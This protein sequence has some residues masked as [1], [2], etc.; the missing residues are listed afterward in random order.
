[1]NENIEIPAMQV[2]PLKKICMTIGEIPTSY[3]ETMSYYEMLVW[4]THYLRDNIIPA[5]NN[6]ASA[7]QEVQTI[8]MELQDYINNYFDNLDV[9]EE[10]DIKI[11]KLVANG[12]MTN[13]IKEY[14]DPIQEAYETSVNTRLD[15][16]DTALENSLV[17]QNTILTTQNQLID[18]MNRK[19]NNV[20][21]GTPQAVSSTSDMTDTTKIYVLTTDGQWYYYDGNDWTA[22]GDYTESAIGSGQVKFYNLYGDVIGNKYEF[23]ADSVANP[24]I[25]FELDNTYQGSNETPLVIDVFYKFKALARHSLTI[26]FNGYTLNKT[27]HTI[28]GNYLTGSGRNSAEAWFN[29]LQLHQT[30]SY[31]HS[32]LNGFGLGLNSSTA[33]D[34]HFTIEDI[35]VYIN[36]EKVDFTFNNLYSINSNVVPKGGNVKPLASKEYTDSK[37]AETIDT[38]KKFTNGILERKYVID[39]TYSYPTLYFTLPTQYRGGNHDYTVTFTPEVY[40]DLSGTLYSL[41]AV[42]YNPFSTNIDGE[43]WYATGKNIRENLNETITTTFTDNH[44]NTAIAIRLNQVNQTAYNLS[45]NDIS[46]SVDNHPVEIEF[47]E[48]KST[49]WEEVVSTISPLITNDEVKS[50]VASGKTIEKIDS[51][52]KSNAHKIACWG[53]SLTEGGTSTGQPYPTVLNELLG[54]KYT[55]YNLGKS[56]QRS[57]AIAFREGAI[58]WTLATGITIPASTSESVSFDINIS[59]GHPINIWNDVVFDVS[60]DGIEGKLTTSG[61]SN[62]TTNISGSFKRNTAGSAKSVNADTQIISLEATHQADLNIIWMGLN[63]VTFAYPYQVTGP[64]NNSLKMINSL[65]PDVKR[66]L[67]ISCTSTASMTPEGDLFTQVTNLNNNYKALYPDQYV[68]LEYYCVHQLIYDMGITPTESDLANM[69]DDIIPASVTADGIHF[70]GEARVFIAEFIY[71]ELCVRGWV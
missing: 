24:F 45:I 38:F 33:S 56:G 50:Y 68:D 31:T 29:P 71:N 47:L 55:V 26:C 30:I 63:D 61:I 2:T 13:I 4:F 40:D 60:I 20:V 6:N 39:G 22:G 5:V 25:V 32:N 28:S 11:D 69:E 70:T 48:S 51:S 34:Y 35:V 1:M 67:I 41:G 10:I 54:D 12:T 16:Q 3:L 42:R 62:Q 59:S 46:V 27:A 14:V 36:G 21:G 9:Q 64:V 43:T 52:K 58:T 8:V 17:A 7:L 66:F 49:A 53:D 19:I 65:T 18:T 37:V 44:E 57:G 23:E 15:N